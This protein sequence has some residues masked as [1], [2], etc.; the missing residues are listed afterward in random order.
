MKH[1]NWGG[2]GYPSY[3]GEMHDHPLDLSKPEAAFVYSV[4]E[5]AKSGDAAEIK[6]VVADPKFKALENRLEAYVG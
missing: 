4:F 5:A 6:K 2:E 1:D 3:A